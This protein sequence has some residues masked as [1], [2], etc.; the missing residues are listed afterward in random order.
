MAFGNYISG[1][2]TLTGSGPDAVQNL[3]VFFNGDEVHFVNGNSVSW[4]FNTGNYPSGATNITLVGADD[5]GELYT[6]NAR[7][8]FISGSLS[9]IITIGIIALI[10]VLAIAKYGSRFLKS[11]K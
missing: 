8:V 6:A 4:Q 10:S 1:T 3:T 2:F 9:T 5:L 11:K 7:F